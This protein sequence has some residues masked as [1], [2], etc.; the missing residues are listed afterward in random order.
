M[1][2]EQQ[3]SGQEAESAGA[4]QPATQDPGELHALLEDARSKA[5]EHWN[6]L[7]RLQAELDNLRKRAER[8]V[9]QAHKFGLEKFAGELL[10]VKD[11]LE[12]GIAA[13]SEGENID[14]AKLKQ[15]FLNLLTNAIDAMPQGG[16][17][18]V[19]AARVD[20]HVCVKISDTGEGIAP[21]R[22]PLI[23]EPFYT[24]KGEGTGLG[25]SITHNIISDHG[26]RIE[27]N[28]QPGGGTEFVLWFPLE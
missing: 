22:L 9:A 19:A 21:D 23:F 16:R 10:P 20:D 17:L 1:S 6:Q 7:L 13:A 11:S 14:A 18:E 28:S 4:E 15:A 8:D 25:L 2:E 24:S 3:V 26:G 12:M 5:D 27:V